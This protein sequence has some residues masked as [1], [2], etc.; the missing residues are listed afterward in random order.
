[1]HMGRLRC[2]TANS[3]PYSCKMGHSRPSRHINAKDRIANNQ[4]YAKHIK[5][6]RTALRA[7]D[8]ALATT[9]LWFVGAERRLP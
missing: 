2:P 1:M 9:P 4:Q 3:Y 7:K 6:R 8:K 5:K